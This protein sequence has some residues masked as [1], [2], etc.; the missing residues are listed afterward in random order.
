[1]LSNVHTTSANR[2]WIGAFAALAPAALIVGWDL[3]TGGPVTPGLIAI[4]GA[5]VVAGWLVGPRATGPIGV[6]IVAAITF[7]VVAYV[8][9][10]TVDIA[11]A[12]VE[13]VRSGATDV[14]AA[15]REGATLLVAR[16]AY[17][18]VFGL[19]LSPAAIAWIAVVRI[20]RG[21]VRRSPR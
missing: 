13:D 2:R 8:L 6:D 16:V 9:E 19:L 10:T 1:M 7:F 3:G 21:A 12:V 20:L 15:L 18:P 11:L 17:L 14:N 4:A 5:C